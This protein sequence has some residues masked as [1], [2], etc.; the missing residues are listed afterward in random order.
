MQTYLTQAKAAEEKAAKVT[1]PQTKRA[2]L[3]IAQGY[4]DLAR[5]KTEPPPTSLPGRHNLNSVGPL[6]FFEQPN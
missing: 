4:R 6:G 5:G 2:W 3:D 1:D